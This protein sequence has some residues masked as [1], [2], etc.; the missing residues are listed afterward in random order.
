M[1]LS[2]LKS[3]LSGNAC[4]IGVDVCKDTLAA[5]GVERHGGFLRITGVENCPLPGADGEDREH[6]LSGMVTGRESIC[7]SLPAGSVADMLQEI[8]STLNEWAVERHVASQG[9]SIGSISD[10]QVIYDYQVMPGMRDGQRTLVISYVKEGVFEDTYDAL[11]SLDASS[12]QATSCGMALASAFIALLPEEAF[13][14]RPQVLLLLREENTVMVVVCNGGI[15]YSG[16]M[17]FGRRNLVVSLNNDGTTGRALLETEYSSAMSRWQEIFQ[18]A[19][20]PSEYD[21]RISGSGGLSLYREMLSSIVP[22]RSI[23]LFGVP[24]NMLP[25]QDESFHAE[26]VVPFGLALQSVGE[27]AVKLS[28]LP[29]RMKW[30]ERKVREYRFLLSSVILMTI[31]LFFLVSGVF[32][33]IN[34]GIS[35]LQN[36]QEKLSVCSGLIPEMKQL[37]EKIRYHQKRMLPVTE[38]IYRTHCYLEALK[39]WQSARGDAEVDEQSWGIYMADEFSFDFVNSRLQESENDIVLTEEKSRSSG[40]FS[41]PDKSRKKEGLVDVENMKVLGSIYI[42]GVVP[43]GKYRYKTLKDVQTNLLNSG[44]YVNVDDHSDIL[45]QGF[46]DRY[47]S[48]WMDFLEGKGKALDGE[49]TTFLIALP[50]SSAFIKNDILRNGGEV[51]RQ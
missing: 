3:S 47:Y 16:V 24:G 17:L 25:G 51:R 44:A 37:H 12:H 32:M 6:C 15:Q 18:S 31:G 23:E 34:R 29:D 19:D 40:L 39:I 8:P 38:A 48:P 30:Y 41:E 35:F 2:H 10:E 4:G 28:L 42:G 7:F 13:S 20:L 50:L 46:K 22:G 45:T 36:E 49:Y 27:S 11:R 5:I 21:I 1:S 43:L 33:Y 14:G 26:L 9:H